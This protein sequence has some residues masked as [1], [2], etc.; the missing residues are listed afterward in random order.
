MECL[1]IGSERIWKSRTLCSY[2]GE[3]WQCDWKK[4]IGSL[5]TIVLN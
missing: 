1:E 4:I 2:S 5:K 3:K